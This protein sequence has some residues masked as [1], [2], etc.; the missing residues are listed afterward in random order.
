MAFLIIL[1]TLQA[2]ERSRKYNPTENQIH[3]PTQ[4]DPKK[5]DFYVFNAIEIMAPPAIVWELLI[6]A[7]SWPKWYKGIQNITFEDHNHFQLLPNTKVFWNS[8]G[9]SLHNVVTEF[10]PMERLAWQ[11]NESK[12][13]G[14]HAWLIIPT[15]LGCRVITAESQ[16]GRLAKLQKLFLPKKLL[17]QHENWLVLLKSESEKIHKNQH[18]NLSIEERTYLIKTLTESHDAFLATIANL[19]ITQLDFKPNSKSWS[20]AECVEHIALAELQFPKIV[21]EALQNRPAP[22]NRKY[23]KINDSDIRSKMV[24]GKWK[25]KSPETFLPVSTFGNPALSIEA[26]TTQR[27]RTIQY[28]KDTQDDLR[29]HYWR[30]PLTGTIDLYQTLL[31][32]SAHLERHIN[33]IKTVQNHPNFPKTL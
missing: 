20:I 15:P 12:I 3:W 10:I 4:F 11:F 14:H 27:I 28:V 8:M 24:D 2:Q 25:A 30:H 29:N 19:S 13:Q 32:M 21:A 16:T 17:K 26:F 33:Q 18:M 1:S 23:I 22:E 7:S 5:S 6:H 9:Q 31:L